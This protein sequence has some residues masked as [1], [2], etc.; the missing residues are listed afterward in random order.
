MFAKEAA[1]GPNRV[2]RANGSSPQDKLRRHSA[3]TKELVF[4]AFSAE[5]TCRQE[6][7]KTTGPNVGAR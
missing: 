5:E 3:E 4:A 2:H 6:D 1:F 7:R